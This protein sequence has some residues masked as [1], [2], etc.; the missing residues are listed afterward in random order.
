[1]NRASA[2]RNAR[3]AV[4]GAE[5][6]GRQDS[7]EKA[8]ESGIHIKREWIAAIDGRTRHVHRLLDGQLADVDKP[9]KSE[10][11]DIMFP[12]DQSAD[13]ANVYN[14]RCTIAAKV[15]SVGGSK[16]EGSI[17]EDAEKTDR[18]TAQDFYNKNPKE[19]DIKQKKLYNKEADKAQF[20][21]YKSRLGSDIPTRFSD[22]QDLK[23]RDAET[24]K[25]TK[26]FYRY[27]GLV[28]EASINDFEIYQ[29]IKE[30]GIVG[31]IRVPAAK[32]DVSNISSA[33]NHA[34]RHGCTLE[35]AKEYIKNAKV[36]ITRSKWDGMHT[37]FYSL[38]GA[39]YINA[40]GQVN[41]IYSKKDFRK[42]TRKILE[43]FE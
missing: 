30:N 43:D 28:P 29:K 39:V 24:Y 17:N 2:I 37:N 31:T 7:Y 5:C 34:F 1:M 13:P 10:L 15:I 32:F 42:E 9:F 22:W 26:A 33:N 3:T 6:R 14:C 16:V 18:K 8:E 12:G 11:G 25:K 4:T 38:D 19:F 35:D 41:T 36:S 20:S 40:N 27:K 21:A 23:Y